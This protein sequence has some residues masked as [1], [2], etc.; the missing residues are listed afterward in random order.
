MFRASFLDFFFSYYFNAFL[1]SCFSAYLCFS[2]SF[3]FS[4]SFLLLF[5]LAFLFCFFVFFGLFAFKMFSFSA[6][7]LIFAFLV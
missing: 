5:L 3:P 7:L 6:S 2:A 4:F 1:L